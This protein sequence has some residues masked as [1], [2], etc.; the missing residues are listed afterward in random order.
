MPTQKGV[1]DAIN[2]HFVRR[3]GNTTLEIVFS[4]HSGG[5]RGRR[6]AYA[7]GGTFHVAAFQGI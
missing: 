1:K 2:G 3:K 6:G 7:P 4:V 5:G